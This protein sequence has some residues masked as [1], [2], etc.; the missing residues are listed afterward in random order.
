MKVR[1]GWERGYGSE[2]AGLVGADNGKR[3]DGV[4][5]DGARAYARRCRCALWA[6][7]R[8]PG[9]PLARQCQ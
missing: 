8:V 9:A 5:A 4:V 1:C 7:G 6:R 2:H 3:S